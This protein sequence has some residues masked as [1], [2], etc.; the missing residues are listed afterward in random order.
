MHAG[1][2]V[3]E[4]LA[5]SGTKFSLTLPVDPEATAVTADEPATESGSSLTLLSVGRRAATLFGEV[6]KTSF[7]LRRVLNAEPSSSTVEGTTRSDGAN[8]ASIEQ[9]KQE[10]EGG[11]R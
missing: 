4:S 3:V 10:S 11:E 6:V 1:R 8:A 2:I 5:G 9:V 7:R